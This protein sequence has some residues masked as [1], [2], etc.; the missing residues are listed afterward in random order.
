MLQN[1]RQNKYC[2]LDII[3]LSV[4]K[5]VCDVAW[6]LQVYVLYFV[7]YIR[8][9]IWIIIRLV[10]LYKTKKVKMIVEG[11]RGGFIGERGVRVQIAEVLKLVLSSLVTS[12]L[13][14]IFT[15]L[16]LHIL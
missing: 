15:P 14:V 2:V 11:K 1:I 12:N 8:Y 7:S 9:F 5:P 3:A 13:P 16:A 10:N 4:E 6:M